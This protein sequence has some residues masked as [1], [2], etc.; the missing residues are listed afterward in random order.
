MESKT[1]KSA[2]GQRQTEN[3]DEVILVQYLQ[4]QIK[5]N[6]V[7]CKEAMWVRYITHT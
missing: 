4:T 2:N 5:T 1:E 6:R 3:K 7:A